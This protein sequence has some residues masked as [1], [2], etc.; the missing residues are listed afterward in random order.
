MIEVRGMNKN[1]PKIPIKL[2]PI[3]TATKTQIEG[4]HTELPT[5]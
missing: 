5:T 2:P 4:S 1:I 3:I